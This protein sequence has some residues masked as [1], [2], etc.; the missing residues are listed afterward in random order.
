ML[1]K[2][3]ASL[4]T[5][6]FPVLLETSFWWQSGLQTSLDFLLTH[7]SSFKHQVFC[8]EAS[9]SPVH[10]EGEGEILTITQHLLAQELCWKAD[11][12]VSK[13]VRSGIN[14]ITHHTTRLP[15]LTYQGQWSTE[16]SSCLRWRQYPASQRTTQMMLQSHPFVL[17]ATHPHLQAEDENTTSWILVL[18]IPQNVQK[19]INQS[20]WVNG[21]CNS[22]YI[23]YTSEAVFLF[24]ITFILPGKF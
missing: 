1:L 22:T 9:V 7:A 18:Y 12:M 16:E 13:N 21:G 2:L 8:R 4:N 6:D 3:S 20:F 5:V 23:C 24:Y 19:A 10:A 14:T 15:S 11:T 17:H